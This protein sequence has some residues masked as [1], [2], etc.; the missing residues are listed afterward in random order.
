MN[1]LSSGPGP[2]GTGHPPTPQR[3]RAR[4]CSEGLLAPESASLL[5]RV[6][7]V[8]APSG[9]PCPHCA[10]GF[11]GASWWHQAPPG[12]P[13]A[14]P[15]ANTVASPRSPPET[16]GEGTELT[17]F[18][19]SWPGTRVGAGAG[20]GPALTGSRSSQASLPDPSVDG[21]SGKVIERGLAYGFPARPWPA[22]HSVGRACVCSAS[23]PSA[24][25]VEKESQ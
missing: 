14:D 21:A 23:M 19:R 12:P 1:P 11:L 5:Q 15:G 2:A 17:I 7:A 10:A 8:L 22:L 25:D 16:P 4:R 6:V 13:A 3:G 24:E 18:T 9:L 20:R